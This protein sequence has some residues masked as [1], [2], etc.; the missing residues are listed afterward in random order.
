MANSQNTNNPLSLS[1][2]EKGN[3]NPTKILLEKGGAKKDKTFTLPTPQSFFW[4]FKIDSLDYELIFFADVCFLVMLAFDHF[5]YSWEPISICRS[6]SFVNP[7]KVSFLISSSVIM[8]PHKSL[9][10]LE[11]IALPMVTDKCVYNYQIICKSI[12][13]NIPINPTQ[14]YTHLKN[15]K[16]IKILQYSK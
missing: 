10:G 7:T 9:D 12:F 16:Y 1:L 8:G 3:K 6:S 5:V 15:R 11:E 2:L 13:T 14:P 4:F